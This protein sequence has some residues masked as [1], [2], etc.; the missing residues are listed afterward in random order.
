METLTIK[1][2]K[3]PG[4]ITEVALEEGA[5]VAQAIEAAEITDIEGFET[6]VNGAPA[7]NDAEL[8]DGDNV[9]LVKKIKGN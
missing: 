8:S 1:I 5:T 7:A 3:L 4:R 6:R 9:L 2:G